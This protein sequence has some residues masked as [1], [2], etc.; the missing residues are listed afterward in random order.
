MPPGRNQRGG[1]GYKKGK[2]KP[3]DEKDELDFPVGKFDRADGEWQD[4]G[5]VLRLLGDRRVLCF[6]NDGNER[7]AK[8]R[9]A[10]CKG[11]KKK[12]IEKG[13]IVLLSF[14]DFMG[15]ALVAG[16]SM[17]GLGIKQAEDAPVTGMALTTS[18]GRKE[19]A[20]LLEKYDRRHWDDI[21][22]LPDI[23]PRLIR[24]MTSD[25]DDKIQH[26]GDDIF[27]GGGAEA[28]ADESDSSSES[29]DEDIDVDAI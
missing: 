29:E 22:H 27:G 23:H 9:G 19:V 24:E 7:I 17:E 5:R 18:T 8:I 25:D 13:D 6:C 1:K 4:Y 14:R 20:D 2:K 11:P 3:T 26:T 21:R 10:L 16:T 28:A 15:R 12:I